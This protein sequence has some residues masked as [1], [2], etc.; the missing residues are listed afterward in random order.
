MGAITG[1]KPERQGEKRMAD[2]LEIL[3]RMLRRMLDMRRFEEAVYAL[4]QEGAF[5]GHYHLYTGQEATGAGALDALDD[6]DP[7]FTTHRNHG[8]LIARGADP[9]AALAE[10]LGRADGLAGGRGGTFHLADPDRAVPHTSALV[11]G[12]VPL[13]A[14]AAWAARQAGRGGAAMAL[15]G[16]G[17]LEEGVVFETLN[18]AKGWNL[19]VI[20]VCENN[21]PG[22]IGRAAGGANSSRLATERMADIA[23]A[24]GIPGQTIDGGDAAV[25]R[26]AVAAARETCRAGGGPSFIEAATVR[27]PGNQRQFPDLVT[28]RTD[29]AMAWDPG[30]IPSQH[31]EWFRDVDPVLRLA[32]AAIEAGAT[33]DEITAMDEV[34]SKRME[35]AVAFA[36]SSPLP[37]PASVLDHVLV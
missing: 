20:F 10:I 27:W 18:I 34:S 17:A 5:S 9:K 21:T 2:G 24:V 8:H 3:R 16:D 30:R 22:A 25:V 14:G 23:D 32:R 11:G 36:K 19:P 7:I 13:A 6:G 12:S 28:G 26:D 35:D 1:V 37:D 29:I 15:F 33:T 4:H 31:A